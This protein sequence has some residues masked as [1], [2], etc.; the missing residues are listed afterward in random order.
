MGCP[1]LGGTP[2]LYD[3]STLPVLSPFLLRVDLDPVLCLGP[4]LSVLKSLANDCKGGHVSSNVSRR[5]LEG[6]L[7]NTNVGTGA[8]PPSGLPP[9]PWLGPTFT[10]DPNVSQPPVPQSLFPRLTGH[11]AGEAG[12][13]DE[14]KALLCALNFKGQTQRDR[15]EIGFFPLLKGITHDAGWWGEKE[16]LP[17]KKCRRLSS[18][19]LGAFGHQID[20]NMVLNEKS[21]QDP[22]WQGLN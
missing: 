9:N 13:A 16:N 4:D 10:R 6:F 15:G 19:E 7:S 18:W 3:F 12:W 22:N 2:D 20:I 5:V 14:G 11:R 8:P 1:F 17:A 21:L